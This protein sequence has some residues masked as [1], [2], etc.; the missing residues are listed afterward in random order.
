MHTLIRIETES[1]MGPYSVGV[2]WGDETP[3][4]ERYHPPPT[5][6]PLLRAVWKK[7]NWPGLEYERAA[8]SFGFKDEAQMR[9]W[10]FKDDWMQAMKAVGLKLTVWEVEDE[11]VHFG[12][13]QLIFNK[14]LAKRVEVRELLDDAEMKGPKWERSTNA[15]DPRTWFRSTELTLQV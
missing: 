10:F 11:F 14:E 7:L 6:D 1:G 3:Y 4:A 9:Q 8:Y 5:Q 15:S 13:R 2:D 12:E